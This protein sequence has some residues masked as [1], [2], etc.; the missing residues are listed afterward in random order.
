MNKEKRISSGEKWLR[1]S[2]KNPKAPAGLITLT[3]KLRNNTWYF[4]QKDHDVDGLIVRQGALESDRFI[5]AS[6]VIVL[7]DVNKKAHFDAVTVAL[8]TLF[9]CDTKFGFMDEIK[10]ICI[11]PSYEGTLNI[12]Y[13]QHKDE[14]YLQD[15][16]YYMSA[17]DFLIATGTQIGFVAELKKAELTRS[18]LEAE[19]ERLKSDDA[20]T[21]RK[22]QALEQQVKD[23]TASRDTYC[24]SATA[25]AE[26]VMRLKTKLGEVSRKFD[27]QTRDYLRE[28]NR[29]EDLQ[30]HVNRL[31]AELE[32]RKNPI[33]K[34]FFGD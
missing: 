14:N 32:K 25:G 7:P 15:T 1:L 16:F 4:T 8:K 29:A 24:K 20:E 10:C 17:G 18:E 26:E 12:S 22:T 28:F 34:F 6:T 11:E 21:A 31:E 3:K 2:T 27:N 23:L 33:R 19:I 9:D 5:P 13:L 30:A